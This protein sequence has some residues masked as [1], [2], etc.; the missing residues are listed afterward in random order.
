[1]ARN[2]PQLLGP[3]PLMLRLRCRP[4]LLA[5][6]S[7]LAS[8][9]IAFVALPNIATADSAQ[10]SNPT[11]ATSKLPVVAEHLLRY[12]GFRIYTV[13]LEVAERGVDPLADVPKIMTI[14]YHRAFTAQEITGA[15]RKL[16]ARKKSV[17]VAELTS[18]LDQIDAVYQDVGENDRYTLSYSP[19]VGTTLL[20]NDKALTTVAGADFAK[21]YF[22]MWLGDEAPISASLRSHLL[23]DI[24]IVVD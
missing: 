14:T 16:L 3:A 13:K 20:L 24:G 6:G 17:N 5:L 11:A 1:M 4:L 22:G 23:E 19:G 18:R 10:T 21:A 7:L 15:A 8:F 12:F 9:S 2:N